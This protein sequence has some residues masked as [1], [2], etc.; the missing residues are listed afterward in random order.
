LQNHHSALAPWS[1]WHSSVTRWVVIV[2]S[3]V[4]RIV[5]PYW[6]SPLC[7]CVFLSFVFA[8]VDPAIVRRV[9][10]GHLSRCLVAVFQLLW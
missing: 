10:V 9:V 1:L 4:C 7:L 2:V 6:S 5:G 3:G 8:M